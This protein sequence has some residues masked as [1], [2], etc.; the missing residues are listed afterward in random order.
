M[1]MNNESHNLILLKLGGSLITDKTRP[2]TP[3]HETLHRLAN[4]IAA[5]LSENP[6]LRLILGNGA[7]SFGHVPAKR[8]NT[9]QGV[10][11]REGWKGF[12]EVWREAAALNQLVSEALHIAGLPAIALHPL[13][14]VIAR[15]GQVASWDVA[16]LR[17][18]LT[19]GLLPIIHGDVCFDLVR[20]GT[21]LS[22]EDLFEYLAKQLSPTRILLAGLEEG[23]WQD[24]PTCKK[25]VPEITPENSNFVASF[26]G[27]SAGIDVTG[28]MASKVQQSLALSQDVPGIE[29]QIFSG[30]EPGNLY[31]ALS[32]T[33]LGTLIHS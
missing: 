20:G 6:D 19:A 10:S 25:L 15:D 12:A 33:R 27:E 11:N 3:R 22:T 9:R 14:A 17:A 4:E 2:R 23:V 8:F 31:Q 13:S 24:Y 1:E 7:G 21:I 32:G 30:E 18:A 26:L 5:A 28:G 16:P 29:I